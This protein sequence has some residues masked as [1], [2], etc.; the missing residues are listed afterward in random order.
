MGRFASG[1]V[2][3]S[4]STPEAKTPVARTVLLKRS[5]DASFDWEALEAL[6]QQW[7][8]QRR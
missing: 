7:P 8:G 5:M 1:V 6:R 3:I 2:V 4:T